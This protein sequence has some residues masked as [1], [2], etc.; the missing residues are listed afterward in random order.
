MITITLDDELINQVMNKSHAKNAEQAVINILSNY[1]R[2]AKEV[3]FFEQIQLTEC[4]D[5]DLAHLFER[6]KDTGRDISL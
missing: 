4:A 5:D 3:P 2:Q 6:D 1:L